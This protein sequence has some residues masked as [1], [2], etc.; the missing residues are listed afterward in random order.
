MSAYVCMYT[1]GKMLDL[2]SEGG[3]LKILLGGDISFGKLLST[4]VSG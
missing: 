1:V 4:S 3:W 2:Q